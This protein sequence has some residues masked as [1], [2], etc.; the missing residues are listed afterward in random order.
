MKSIRNRKEKN[1]YLNP[2]GHLNKKIVT[3]CYIFSAYTKIKWI[4][5]I[6]AG[7]SGRNWENTVRKS[8]YYIKL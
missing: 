1:S 8:L 5:T 6:V 3:M 2:P 4:T 7:I